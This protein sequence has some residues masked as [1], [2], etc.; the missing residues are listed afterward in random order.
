MDRSGKVWGA[1]SKLFNKNNVEVHMITVKKGGF[2]SIHKHDHKHN[3]FVVLKGSII[4]HEWK[5][6]L[7]DTTLL[8]CGDHGTIPPGNFHQFEAPVDAQVL[9]IY[10]ISLDSCDIIR[11]TIGGNHV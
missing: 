9:E 4:I 6:D 11:K 8:A 2:C 1:T 5:N 3:M 7:K 10:W